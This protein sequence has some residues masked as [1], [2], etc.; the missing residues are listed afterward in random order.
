MDKQKITGLFQIIMPP[1]AGVYFWNYGIDPTLLIASLVTGYLF[2]IIAMAGYHRILSHRVVKTGNIFKTLYSII[3][4]ISFTAP[5][6]AWVSIHTLHHWFSDTEQ[7]PHSPV[8]LGL[9]KS[10]FMYFHKSVTKIVQGLSFRDRKKLLVSMSHVSKDPVLLFFEKYYLL[11]NLLYATI[12]FAINPSYVI[13]FYV[14]PVIYGHMGLVWTIINH[15]GFL[16]GQN[17]GSLNK[18]YNKFF[19]WQIFF[20]EHNHSDHH[21]NPKRDDGMNILL[22]KIFW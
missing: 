7:D 9:F 20:G 1:I 3:G 13:Y 8:Q 16:G 5:P 14:I 10:S 11:I 12:L 19:G 15:G 4:S 21:T 6:I 2:Y 18:A 22:R 17:E